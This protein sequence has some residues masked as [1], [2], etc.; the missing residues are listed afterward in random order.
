MTKISIFLYKYFQYSRFVQSC[1]KREKEREKEIN[2]SANKQ[3]N[4]FYSN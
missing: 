2:Y 4:N 3:K 1:G